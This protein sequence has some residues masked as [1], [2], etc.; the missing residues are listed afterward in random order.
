MDNFRSLVGSKDLWHT[1]ECPA[2]CSYRLDGVDHQHESHNDGST[3]VLGQGESG[4]WEL[5]EFQGTLGF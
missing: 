4:L 5:L 1:R 2:R 3:A